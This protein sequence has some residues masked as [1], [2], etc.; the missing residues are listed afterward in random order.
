VQELNSNSKPGKVRGKSGSANLEQLASLV[1]YLVIRIDKLEEKLLGSHLGLIL[2]LGEVLGKVNRDEAKR[3]A[4]QVFNE[5]LDLEDPQRCS[6]VITLVGK[7]L[8][9]NRWGEDEQGD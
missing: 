4:R 2:Y 1:H 8:R 9:S 6:E 5:D 3:L 7:T